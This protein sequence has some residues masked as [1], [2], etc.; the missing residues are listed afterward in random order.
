MSAPTHKAQD[1]IETTND[2]MHACN[3]NRRV[4]SSTPTHCLGH[5]LLL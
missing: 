3:D 5:K 2:N 1:I 4:M